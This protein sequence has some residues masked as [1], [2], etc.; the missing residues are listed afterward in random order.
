MLFLEIVLALIVAPIAF[1]L[2]IALGHY[3]ID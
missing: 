2:L 1:E 3:I